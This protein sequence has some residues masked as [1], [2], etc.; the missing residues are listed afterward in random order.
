MARTKQTVRMSNRRY[1]KPYKIDSESDIDT[2]EELDEEKIRKFQRKLRKIMKSSRK[3]KRT[4]KTA[5][6]STGIPPPKKLADKAGFASATSGVK[7]PHRYRH[8]RDLLH[9][10]R[11]YPSAERSTE[12]LIQASTSERFAL[13]IYSM[14]QESIKTYLISWLK[15]NSFYVIHTDRSKIMPKDIN[16]A[17]RIRGEQ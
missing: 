7:K 15:N 3:A 10:I 11:R 6:E 13:E 14:F 2:D 1:L 4:K 8:G 5:R 9:G 12:R 17:R 16:L